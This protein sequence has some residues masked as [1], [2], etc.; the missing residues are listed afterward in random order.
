MATVTGGQHPGER[1]P[2]TS[3]DP[4]WHAVRGHLDA[5][6]LRL[7][8]A[9]ANYPAPITGCDTHFNTLIE[10]QYRVAEELRRLDEIRSGAVTP[11]ERRA[12][13]ATFIATSPFFDEDARRTFRDL[14]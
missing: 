5:V 1:L 14:P 9:V 2:A 8:D 12:A 11:A 4:A 3:A 7:H 10:E 6:R 13:L